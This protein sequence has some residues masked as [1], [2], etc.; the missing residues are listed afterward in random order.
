MV[1]VVVV[2]VLNPHP[3]DRISHDRASSSYPTLPFS[4]SATSTYTTSVVYYYDL[5]KMGPKRAFSPRHPCADPLH[6]I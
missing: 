3:A 4:I 5:S 6:S 1:V 2:V